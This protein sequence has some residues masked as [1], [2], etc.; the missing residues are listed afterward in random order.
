[1]H[2]WLV[3]IASVVCSLSAG[4]C[5]G[6]D[7]ADSCGVDP[8]TLKSEPLRTLGG[9]VCPADGS[10]AKLTLDC[11]CA[12]FPDAC[13][14]YG[15]V[16]ADQSACFPGSDQPGPSERRGCGQ[17]TVS[18]DQL[19]S[20]A[21]LTYDDASLELIAAYVFSDVPYGPCADNGVSIYSSGEIPSCDDVRAC[22]LCDGDP[23]ACEE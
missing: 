9:C 15:D 16:E 7:D 3:A 4:A 6:S 22:S 2:K 23:N 1:M 12:E 17:R 21:S 13:V 8:T 19:F 5:G 14:S 18:N 11:F 20:G 10:E